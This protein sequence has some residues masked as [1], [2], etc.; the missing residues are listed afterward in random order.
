MPIA[1]SFQRDAWI[2]AGTVMA[3]GA[4]FAV[5]QWLERRW[6][7][8]DLPG[9]DARH[10]ARKDVRRLLGSAVMAAIALAIVAST[11]IDFRAGRAEGRLFAWTWMGILLGVVVLLALALL[12]WQANRLYARRHRR[13]LAEERRALLEE[14]RRH[15]RGNPA[16]EEPE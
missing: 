12:D 6:R 15:A 16:P 1:A 8:A 10:F 4:V 14:I 5:R 7:P 13:A 9:A 11:R 2:L 3:V